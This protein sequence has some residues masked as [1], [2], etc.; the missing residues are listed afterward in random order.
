MNAAV[1]KPQPVLH[2]GTFA[3]AEIV[4][5]SQDRHTVRPFGPDALEHAVDRSNRTLGRVSRRDGTWRLGHVR[6]R[7]LF[8][9]RDTMASRHG[10]LDCRLERQ[11]QFLERPFD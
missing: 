9:P 4:E 8:E 7:S 6:Q 1:V 2:D 5:W 3:V 11:L 10:L